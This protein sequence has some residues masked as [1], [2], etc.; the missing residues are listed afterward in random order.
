MEN[1]SD[2]GGTRGRTSRVRDGRRKTMPRF[3]H[4][5]CQEIRLMGQTMWQ[6]PK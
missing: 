5:R 6:I 2:N 3:G 1:E 4:N